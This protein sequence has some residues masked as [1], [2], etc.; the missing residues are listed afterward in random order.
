MTHPAH[1]LST[2]GTTRVLRK[3]SGGTPIVILCRHR[4]VRNMNKDERRIIAHYACSLGVASADDMAV[5]GTNGRRRAIAAKPEVND[6]II[7][8]GGAS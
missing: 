4:Q 1:A 8:G 3:P 2:S 7:C 6:D 5:L